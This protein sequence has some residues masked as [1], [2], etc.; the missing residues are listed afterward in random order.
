MFLVPSEDW[1]E[2]WQDL[3]IRYDVLPPESGR[4]IHLY[5]NTHTNIGL[6]YVLRGKGKGKVHPCTGT[7][8]L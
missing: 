5:H 3:L 2:N 8:A 6:C 7:E 1:F 4:F